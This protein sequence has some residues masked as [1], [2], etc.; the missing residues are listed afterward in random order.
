MRNWDTVAK[1]YLALTIVGAVAWARELIVGEFNVYVM[2]GVPV[3]SVLWLLPWFVIRRRVLE[4]SRW[5]PR[6]A[7]TL[8]LI[9]MLSV[10]LLVIG[11][12]LFSRL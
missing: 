7:L 1:L 5:I 11:G 3:L 9:V 10:P 6:T 12:S 8:T 4:E 2:F